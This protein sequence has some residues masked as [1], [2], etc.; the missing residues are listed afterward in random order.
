MMMMM[1]YEIFCRLDWIL[2]RRIAEQIVVA[3]ELD[4]TV[5]KM[6]LKH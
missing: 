6:R 4:T 1:A 2:R 3:F 5:F